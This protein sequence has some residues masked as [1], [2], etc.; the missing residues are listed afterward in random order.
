M[1]IHSERTD[2]QQLESNNV[3]PCV[4]KKSGIFF[5]FVY[6]FLQ[7]LAWRRLVKN[8]LILETNMRAENTRLWQSGEPSPLPVGW[9]WGQHTEASH[10]GK[11]TREKCWPLRS[12]CG[13]RAPHRTDPAVYHFLCNAGEKNWQFLFG[14]PLFSFKGLQCLTLSS[15]PSFQSL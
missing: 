6:N 12:G 1:F 11:G 15:V 10:H 3:L 9:W 7:L 13:S 5:F 2:K 8:Y 14:V 4:K